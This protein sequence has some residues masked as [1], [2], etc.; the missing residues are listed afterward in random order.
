MIRMRLCAL[1]LLPATVFASDL[2]SSRDQLVTVNAEQTFAT[3]IV[4]DS[5]G[6]DQAFQTFWAYVSLPGFRV[7][8]KNV[9]TAIEVD[10][11]N[12]SLD[13]GGKAITSGV[14]QRYGAFAGITLIETEKQRGSFLVGGGVASD[15][16]DVNARSAYCHLIYDHRFLI[17][18]RFTFGIGILVA[19]ELGHWGNVF[20]MPVNLLPSL[21]WNIAPRTILKAAWDNLTFEQGIFARTSLFAELR[22][23]LSFYQ[24]ERETRYGFQSVAACGGVNVRVAGNYFVRVRYKE[25]LFKQDY[26]DRSGHAEVLA[27]DGRGRAIGLSFVYAK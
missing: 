10:L 14:M 4:D 15:F 21:T 16:A 27:S 12:R 6:A 17:S 11:M 1:L 25:L 20:G 23:D 8:G 2:L 24:L 19:Y 3:A 18:D 13:W 26:L 7:L 5:L 9:F 22:Y